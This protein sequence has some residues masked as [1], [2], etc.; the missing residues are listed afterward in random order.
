VKTQAE[1]D[2]V[3]ERIRQCGV[4]D[5]LNKWANM[6]PAALAVNEENT[7]RLRQQST[8]APRIKQEADV[9]KPGP[10]ETKLQEQRADAAAGRTK[11]PQPAYRVAGS[12]DLALIPQAA[13]FSARQ[14][15][16]G[17]WQE[18]TNFA[19]LDEARGHGAKLENRNPKARRAMVYAV[20]ADGRS[21]LVPRTYQAPAITP[22]ETTMLSEA[23]FTGLTK[24]ARSMNDKDLAYQISN[25]GTLKM[26][27]AA[28]QIFKDEQAKRASKKPSLTAIAESMKT[29][30]APQTKA[31]ARAACDAAAASHPITRVPPAAKIRS[32]KKPAAKKPEKPAP[33]KKA[34][35]AAKKPAKA[36]PAAPKKTVD[37]K[38][39]KGKSK[40]DVVHDML[41]REKGAT[42]AEL[43]KASG[44]PHVN[45]PASAERAGMDLVC[46]DKDEKRFKLIAKKS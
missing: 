9:A 28:T 5:A 42:R 37:V 31:E 17:E 27:A 21:V 40:L 11:K 8:A 43:S 6:T 33:A 7:K 44:W 2:A 1:I 29:G 36:A 41:I 10:K 12:E 22:K 19:S 38:V 15:V 3:A 32:A 26:P 45:L 18:G 34:K 16:D 13:S 4:P 25:A 14:F 30:T 35:A 24:T 23:E 46:L 39:P 20:L